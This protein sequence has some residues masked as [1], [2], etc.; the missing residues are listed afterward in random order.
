MV[1]GTVVFFTFQQVA[2]EMLES[3]I[4]FLLQTPNMAIFVN[5]QLRLYC[6][7]MIIS[8]VCVLFFGYKQ[9][10]RITD[11]LGFV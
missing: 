6:E 4:A 11:L 10:S 2:A 3:T 8:L 9:Q 5:E 1:I 7:Q